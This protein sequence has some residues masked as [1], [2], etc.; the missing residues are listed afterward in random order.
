MITRTN[1]T[2]SVNDETYSSILANAEKMDMSIS[3]YVCHVL[4]DLLNVSDEEVVYHARR[5]KN[6]NRFTISCPIELINKANEL[7][8]IKHTTASK[9]ISSQLMLMLSPVYQLPPIEVDI[10]ISD[11]KKTIEYLKEVIKNQSDTITALY[12]LI[13]LQENVT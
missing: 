12:K 5:I 4:I 8:D 10:E 2:L 9:L 1:I 6:Y 13:N 3:G 11:D 7:A